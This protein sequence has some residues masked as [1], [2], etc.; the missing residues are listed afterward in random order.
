MT[1]NSSAADDP[2]WQEL[3]ACSALAG[4]AL[5][6]RT[7]TGSTNSD[8]LALGR[9]GATAGTIVLA[10][11]QTGGRGRLGRSWFSPPGGGLYFSMLL[12]PALAPAELPKIT[13]AAGVALCNA[14][15]VLCRC[16]PLI[17]WPNDLLLEGKK[18][19]GILTESEFGPD[20]TPLVVLGIGINVSTLPAAFPKELRGRVTSLADHGA[21]PL[22][23][24]DLLREIIS[25]VDAIIARLEAGEFAAILA[26][27]RSLDATKGKRLTWVTTTGAAVTGLSLG[28][29]REGLLHIRDDQGR[30]HAVLSGDIL[31]QWP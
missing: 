13:L 7:E 23:R 3:S 15:A 29:D 12:R 21:S 10:R 24:L 20:G 14:V 9:A 5:V 22:R 25:G 8:A 26:A 11:S 19:G 30:T 1:A 28:P 6:L 2:F 17:K 4:H 18:C 27:W 31:V 16:A